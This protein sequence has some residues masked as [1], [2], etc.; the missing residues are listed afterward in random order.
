MNYQCFE[1]IPA[2]Q[3]AMRLA[4]GVFGLSNHPR[5]RNNPGLRDRLEQSAM[6]ISTRIANSC[7]CG[8]ATGQMRLLYEARDATTEVRSLLA[9]LL[10]GEAASDLKNE[11]TLLKTLA[12]SC[13]RQ[14]RGWA[15]A[16][17]NAS[18]KNTGAEDRSGNQPGIEKEPSA[19][20]QATAPKKR[21]TASW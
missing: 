20:Q 18:Q 1:E 19:A 21:P 17:R 5:L 11:I 2:W 3:E 9:F 13:S 14:L 12:E 10:P 4:D 6:A 8:Y 7:E 15:Q 16:I